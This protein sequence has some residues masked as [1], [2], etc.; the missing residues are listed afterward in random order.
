MTLS[1]F[2]VCTLRK[3]GVILLAFLFAPPVFS[4]VMSIGDGMASKIEKNQAWQR[5][6]LSTVDRHVYGVCMPLT[7]LVTASEVNGAPLVE[8][9]T[10]VLGILTGAMFYFRKH[11][12]SNR[13]PESVI[14]GYW[15]PYR[16]ESKRIGMQAYFNKY[17]KFCAEK[18]I[19]FVQ[20]IDRGK[21]EQN[22]KQS[23]RLAVQENQDGFR[24]AVGAI[25]LG[26]KGG[27]APKSRSAPKNIFTG[28]CSAMYDEYLSLPTDEGH[29][30]FAYRTHPT[31]S[32]FFCAVSSGLP[33]VERAERNAETRCF[34]ELTE[35]TGGNLDMTCKIYNSQ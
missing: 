13:I 32:G 34:A 31:A 19:A 14:D 33:S 11:Q 35:A 10:N 20:L 21:N 4:G 26:Q 12:L 17:A 30:A 15:A 22:V 5:A 8:E 1:G 29:K 6:A 25:A 9:E 23:P 27:Q 16:E 28:K 7:I 18:S 2:C 3:F 24:S